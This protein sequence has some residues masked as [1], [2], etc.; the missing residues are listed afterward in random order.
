[1][2][3]VW[4]SRLVGLCALGT[5]LTA[6]ANAP[7][8]WNN[9]VSVEV[10]TDAGRALPMYEHSTRGEVYKAYLEA[11]PQARYRIKVRNN[12]RDRVGLVIAVDGRNIISGGQSTL[13]ANEKMYLL[14]P[15]ETQAYE[16]WRTGQDRVNR[17]YFTEAGDS[18]AETFGDTSALGVIAVAV[19][20]EIPPP[21]QAISRDEQRLAASSEA[22]GRT[23]SK[24]SPSAA[25][26]EPTTGFGETE[27]S[28]SV[29]VAF[30]PESQAAERYFM[31]YYWRE[32][33]CAR[34]IATR[35]CPRREPPPE[36]RR[37][38]PPEAQDD[39]RSPDAQA[40]YRPQIRWT[41]PVA[42]EIVT[43]SGSALPLYEHSQRNGVYKAY[44]EAIKGK[45]YKLRARNNTRDRVGLVIAVDGRNIVS[46]DRSELRAD[47]RMYILE[48][49]ETQTYEGWRTGRNKV[50]RF[51]FTNTGRSYAVDAFG[52]TSALG[53]I[54][55]AVF[56]EQAQV[57]SRPVERDDRNEEAARPSAQQPA[58]GNT[59]F[60]G[61]LGSSKPSTRSS[62]AK[63]APAADAAATG[64]G[65]TEHSPSVSVEFSP[66]D[67][68]LARYY[69][70]YEWREALCAQGIIECRRESKPKPRNRLWDEDE[71]YAPIPQ[72]RR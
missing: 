63:A 19:Y 36:T 66:Q 12:T 38:P 61:L 69:A 37:D 1:M 34:Q 53:V 49:G 18:Y 24:P 23:R 56:A 58:V 25:K 71:G 44:L 26:A 21:P 3:R 55:V 5:L 10:V 57:V 60:G 27:H 31:R 9:D 47:E 28:P 2:M 40:G 14:D 29:R 7:V 30:S 42:L 54:A 72:H 45:G 17:F 15:G 39:R 8:R 22:G 20:H 52:D 41:E 11:E 62:G 67:R 50:N 70:K 65:R 46:G 35:N 32:T 13:N 43:D 16:G 64:F 33:L 59:P 51:Y 4:L 48:P 6:Q 68:P